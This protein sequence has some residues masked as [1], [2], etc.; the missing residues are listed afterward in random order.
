DDHRQPVGQLRARKLRDPEGDGF[1]GLGPVPSPL[2]FD[3]T[4][5][6]HLDFPRLLGGGTGGEKRCRD[7]ECMRSSHSAPPARLAGGMACNTTRRSGARMVRANSR[8]SSVVTS[9]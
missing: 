6:L 2:L 1:A 8:V 3:A 5:F 4:I 9:S 7:Q